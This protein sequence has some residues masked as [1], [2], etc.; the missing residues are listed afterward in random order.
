MYL[1][2]RSFDS[3]MGGIWLRSEEGE[4][5]RP[6]PGVGECWSPRRVQQS[7]ATYELV[8]HWLILQPAVTR[9]AFPMQ[10][11]ILW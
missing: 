11:R 9:R 4:R 5:V 7:L 6:H 2:K 1:P 8:L 3:N 10:S